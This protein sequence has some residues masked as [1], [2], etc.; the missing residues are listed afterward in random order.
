LEIPWA[1]G[2]LGTTVLWIASKGVLG[3]CVRTSGSRVAVLEGGWPL[4]VDRWCS[5]WIWHAGVTKSHTLSPTKARDFHTARGVCPTWRIRTRRGGR[6]AVYGWLDDVL[7]WNCDAVGRARIADNPPT[8][9]T[10]LVKR[11]TPTSQTIKSRETKLHNSTKGKHTCN[12]AYGQRNLP[13]SVSTC[14]QQ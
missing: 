10:R 11:G 1:R 9:S 4:G 8:L 7:V 12:D 13:T 6:S 5:V 3:D 2:E 14:A